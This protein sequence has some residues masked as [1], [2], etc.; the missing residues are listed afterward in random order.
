M[1]ERMRAIFLLGIS[2]AVSVG[3]L[4]WISGAAPS[5]GLIPWISLISA[6]AYFTAG[7]GYDGLVKPMAAGTLAIVLTAVALSI[8]AQLGGGLM[9]TVF[10]VA[11]LAFTII[12]F[13]GIPWFAHIP[14]AFMAAATYVGAGGS[15]SLSLLFIIV[16]WAAGLLLAWI[17]DNL[18]RLL[19]AA[20]GRGSATPS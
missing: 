6:G 10:V 19:I 20:S 2:A 7:A 5:L 18:S 15:W 17:I 3:C 11:S 12:L 1:E 9:T 16:S 8:I 4:M 13:S 14:S